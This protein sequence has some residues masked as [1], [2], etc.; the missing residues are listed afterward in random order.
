VRIA[1]GYLDGSVL[2]TE[3][4]DVTNRKGQ[5]WLDV[6]EDAAQRGGLRIQIEGASGL[7]IYQPA[8]PTLLSKL[9]IEEALVIE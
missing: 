4:R 6:S 5:A 8:E 9:R 3:A 7:V 1:L 2:V